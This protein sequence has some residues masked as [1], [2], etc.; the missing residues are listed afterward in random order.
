VAR[1]GVLIRV[2][3]HEHEHVV[4]ERG[5]VADVHLKRDQPGVVIGHD[6]R[7][8]IWRG[9]ILSLRITE[10]GHIGKRPTAPGRNQRARYN[11]GTSVQTSEGSRKGAAGTRNR[12]AD[13]HEIE[14]KR[15]DLPCRGHSSADTRRKRTIIG[16]RCSNRRNY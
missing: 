3:E 9:W 7:G 16:A 8:D 11:R 4:R 12:A 5:P 6:D 10:C 1:G 13:R 15:G 14:A 2:D